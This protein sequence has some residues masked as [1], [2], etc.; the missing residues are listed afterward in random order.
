[1]DEILLTCLPSS[2]HCGYQPTQTI[3]KLSHQSAQDCTDRL[4]RITGLL[5]LMTIRVESS[6]NISL[7]AF[8]SIR[9][10]MGGSVYT[11]ESEAEG[12]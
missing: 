5:Q 4:P 12:R 6:R 7:D 9:A 2:F 1:V 10:G 11:R 8:A 3:S